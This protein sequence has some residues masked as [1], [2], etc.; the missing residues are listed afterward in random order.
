MKRVGAILSVTLMLQG[1]A[2]NYVDSSGAN[3]TIG[4]AH[5]IQK[6][7]K[8]DNAVAN[9]H[10]V[11]AVGVYFLVM[12]QSSSF[13]VGYT[14]TYEVVIEEDNALSLEL[15]ESNP[16]NLKFKTTNSL[17]KQGKRDEEK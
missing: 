3:H 11:K 8:K 17:I 15:K 4:F 6:K 14:N 9:I 10:Q 2:I 16:I 1:C 7:E 13:G 5:V 12:E